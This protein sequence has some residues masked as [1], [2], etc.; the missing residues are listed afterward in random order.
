MR[1]NINKIYDLVLKL[2][3]DFINQYN[4]IDYD[5]HEY[6]SCVEYW[7]HKVNDKHPEYYEILNSVQTSQYNNLVLLR[8]G[9][10]S[11]VFGGEC[12][13]VE[14]W[15]SFDGIYRHCRSIVID[16]ENDE[17]VILPFDKFFNLNEIEET[18]ENVVRQK[19][20]E[21]L[22]NEF[23]DIDITNKLDGSMQCARYYKGNFIMSGSQSINPEQ[24]WRLKDGYS[25]LNDDYK[26]LLRSF[27][28]HTFIFEYISKEDVHVVNYNEDMYGLHL[29]GARN[30]KTG[31][32]STHK[33]L[34]VLAENYNIKIS[35]RH[36]ISFDEMLNSLSKYK[37]NEKEG[38]VIHISKLNEDFFVKIKCDDYVQMHKIL[39]A[40]SSVNLIIK[41]IGNDTFDDLLSKV[42]EVYRGRVLEL[43]NKVFKYNAILTKTFNDF[44]T[45]VDG[46]EGELKDKMIW[47]TTNVPKEVQ[48]QVREYVKSGK[49]HVNFIKKKNTYIKMGEIEEF[50][51]LNGK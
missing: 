26:K 41:S 40:I 15:D 20:S 33:I 49:K 45:K 37:S 22:K 14:F 13:Y 6:S 25:M 27:P 31:L 11:D 8:Y 28:N 21:A 24:S 3:K 12:D 47:I 35:E 39:S 48:G 44:C 5:K 23:S 1:A 4:I 10:Y 19:I 29:I 38:Y 51:F 34:K 42:P 30:V 50:L 32:S 16:V 46:I 9:N 18:N 36:N 43:A 2:K 17:I 7:A